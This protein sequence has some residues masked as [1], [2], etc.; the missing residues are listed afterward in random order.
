MG[1][2]QQERGSRSDKAAEKP[3]RVFLSSF[4]NKSQ[5]F[6]KTI[7]VDQLVIDNAKAKLKK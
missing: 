4:V 6:S 2:A 1:K 5:D 3:K 7:I